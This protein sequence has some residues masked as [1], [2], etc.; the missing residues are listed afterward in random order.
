MYKKEYLELFQ[1]FLNLAEAKIRQ[2]KIYDKCYPGLETM[3]AKITKKIEPLPKK[4]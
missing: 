1:L 4:E 2:I 3:L